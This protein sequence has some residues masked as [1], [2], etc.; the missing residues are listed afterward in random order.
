MR[1]YTRGGDDGSTGLFGG[2][3]VSKADARVEAYGALDE[4]NAVL[5]WVRAGGCSEHVDGVLDGAQDACFRLGAWLASVP[6][7]DPGVAPL[8][9]EDVDGLEAAIDAM[10]IQLDPLKTFVL[11]GGCEVAARLHVAR[12]VCRRAERRLVA[13][14]AEGPVEGA[15]I[16]WVNRL[17]DLLFVQARWVN[18]RAGVADVPWQPRTG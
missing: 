2:A 7:K 4:L 15:W 12:T 6:G 1:I 18:R 17:S 3:R 16:R 14:A 11:P 9:R 10:E 5:G 13:L 8:G